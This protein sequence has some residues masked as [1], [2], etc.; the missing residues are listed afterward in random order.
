MVPCS[1]LSEFLQSVKDGYYV[2]RGLESR[3]DEAL[4]ATQPG[5][6]AA[7]YLQS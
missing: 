4:F 6:G 2:A 3:V 1:K 5:S 7:V